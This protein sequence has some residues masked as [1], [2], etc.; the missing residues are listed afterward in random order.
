MMLVGVL[1]VCALVLSIVAAIGQILH[2][3]GVPTAPV[4]DLLLWAV[5]LKVYVIGADKE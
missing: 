5:L 2:W 3:F 1:E 4:T